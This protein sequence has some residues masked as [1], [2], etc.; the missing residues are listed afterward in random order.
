M[1]A[2]PLSPPR[3]NQLLGD[4]PA[5]VAAVSPARVGSLDQFL[6]PPLWGR[7]GVGGCCHDS[8]APRTAATK[9][10]NLAWSLRP[11]SA[12]TPLQT[13]TAQGCSARTAPSTLAG[14][15]P[16]ETTTG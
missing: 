2:R 14:V 6:P 7:V 12:S 1:E 15:S 4:D 5:A 16:P 3:R 9:A 10:R 11:G 8:L 13:S